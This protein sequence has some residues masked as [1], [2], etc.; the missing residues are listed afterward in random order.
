MRKYKIVNNGGDLRER[1]E[2][3]RKV[4]AIIVTITLS[5]MCLIG[6]T[7][8]NQPGDDGNLRIGI[9]Q[10][11]PHPSLDNCR[12]GFIEGLKALGFTDDNV[13]FD[14]Q[15][16]NADMNLANTIAQKMVADK[17]DLIVGIATPAAQAAFN[18]TEETDIPVV[19]IAVSDPVGAG[20]SGHE[21]VTGVSDVLQ[22]HEQIAL[23]KALIPDAKTVGVIYNT[24][25][26]NSVK[27]VAMLEEAAVSEGF[28]FETA[29]VTGVSDV[30]L[31]LESLLTKI[32]VLINVLDNTVV[33]AMATIADK[34]SERG[35]A[36][37]G[38]EEEQ[39]HNGAL[40]S[41]GFDYF[42]VGAQSAGLAARMFNNERN[43]PFELVK[44]TQV[45]INETVAAALNVTIPTEIADSASFVN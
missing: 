10:F 19:F 33:S 38:S 29:T 36:I 32:D 25:E 24:G 13:V 8:G 41:S 27:Q 15:N 7:G 43:I 2:E 6:C 12:E 45:V 16:A 21:N 11:A 14:Y 3:M 26:V 22:V 18:A 39:V 23:V 9:I 44:E 34:C 17:C 37:I 40:A 4:A 28:S 30:N 1:K 5:V 35:I 42:D 20:L 31:A